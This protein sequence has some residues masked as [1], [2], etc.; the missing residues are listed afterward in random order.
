M[1]EYRGLYLPDG[2]RVGLG[3]FLVR[4]SSRSPVSC[5]G[6]HGICRRIVYCK[7]LIRGDLQTLLAALAQSMRSKLRR[8]GLRIS[9]KPDNAG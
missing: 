8:Q 3:W 4:L 5:F 1:I 6:V 7:R 2:E 9:R